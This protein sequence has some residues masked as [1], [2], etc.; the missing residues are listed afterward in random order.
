M[1]DSINSLHNSKN[2]VCIGVSETKHYIIKNTGAGGR[3]CILGD[4]PTKKAAWEDAYGPM[5]WVNFDTGRGR[6]PVGAW[7]EETTEEKAMD[8]FNKSV[9]GD[10]AG[11][12]FYDE[13]A[14]PGPF[15]F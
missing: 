4:G 2:G 5:P 10:H 3:V 6:F 8:D 1:S 14:L 13:E 11:P 9:N 7:I 12:G 15:R